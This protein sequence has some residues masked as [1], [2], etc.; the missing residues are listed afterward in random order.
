MSQQS[1]P[2]WIRWTGFLW[3]GLIVALVFSG[4]YWVGTW[5]LKERMETFASK[6]WGA[7]VEAASL[8]L[9]LFPPRIEL[10]QLALT[11]PEQV[12]ENLVTI[13]QASAQVNLYH[14]VSGRTVIERLQISEL[15]L[16]QP[17]ETSGALES[18]EPSTTAAIDPERRPKTASN[19]QLPEMTLPDAQTLLAR[20]PLKTVQQAEKIQ[21]RVTALKQAWS[22]LKP[23]LPTEATLQS[24]Q[25]QFEALKE[26][27]IES[28]Q[29][30]QRK[31]AQFEA[32]KKDMQ[33]KRDALKEARDLLAQSIPAL[34]ADVAALK[35]LPQQDLNRLMNQYTLDG[36]GLVQVTQLLFGAQ[37]RAYTQK[38]LDWYQT[39][40]PFMARAQAMWAEKQAQQ[41]DTGPERLLGREVTFALQDPQ[42]DWIIQ[43]IDVSANIDWGQV[44]ARIEQ[45]TLDHPKTQ[46]PVQFAVAL[47]P[48]QQANAL[49]IEGSSSFVD[50][51]AP[52]NQARFQW[53]DFALK[54]WQ[55]AKDDTLP[56]VMKKG[57]A[58]MQGQVALTGL[59]QVN[60]EVD[61]HYDAVE[62]DVS[63][64]DS[65]EVARY[66]APLFEQVS[67]LTLDA[68]IQGPISA[69]E[70]DARSDLD[71][72]LS[73]AFQKVLGQEVAR[74]KGQLQ[75]RLQARLQDHKGPLQDSL[76]GLVESKAWVQGDY[77]QIQSL[78]QA[79]LE[80][81]L[82]QRLKGRAKEAI[83]DKVEDKVKEQLGDQVGD[84][85]KGLFGR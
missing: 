61:V 1:K 55:L 66:V 53:S 41:T 71:Q 43:Q 65:K 35:D 73:G 81:Q 23:K 50:P 3:L 60:A 27:P 28:L 72:V 68:Q 49:Q 39:L 77:Q 48:A 26:G 51:T 58:S 84:Q 42:P 59:T 11:D 18:A 79:N 7:Q 32:L 10:K 63:Q 46:L 12:M 6:A 24:Y 64:T 80:K 22:Q 13:E 34:R 44:S 82:K 74:L 69:L 75:T 30:V 47:K 67:A 54:D 29:T 5:A 40:Q 33:T 31:V 37:I 85:L 78:M 14:W 16:H 20:E 52:V 83:E 57:Q 62:L 70:I 45:L 9:G 36:Q 8:S 25:D 38:A 21:S 17:R 2:G 15:S 76:S 19:F 56:V 4:V